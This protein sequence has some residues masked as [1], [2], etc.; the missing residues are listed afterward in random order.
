DEQREVER[1]GPLVLVE[2]LI[3]G[4][5]EG[6]ALVGDLHVEVGMIGAMEGLLEIA[7]ETRPA[8]LFEGPHQIAGLDDPVGVPL[9]IAVH[10][11]PEHGLAELVA[12]RV[13]E[14]A[15]LLVEV[16]IEDVDRG[17]VVLA[18]DGPAVAAA[19]LA[20]VGLE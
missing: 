9:E 10:A 5:R 14:E 18:D 4:D 1:E 3:Y 19:A 13:Q 16:A 12:Q 8:D 7:L 17:L 20:E 6:V 11:A 2:A 15:A